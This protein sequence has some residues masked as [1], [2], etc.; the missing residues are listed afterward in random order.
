MTM[1][2]IL[3]QWVETG[4]G[5]LFVRTW[6][7]GNAEDR[8]PIL[9]VH[10]S[11]GCIALWRDFPERLAA[12]TLRPVIA[13]DR[14]GFGRSDPHP[15]TLGFDF[16]ADEAMRF[17][18][19]IRAQ[20]GLLQF[21]ACGHSVGGGMAVE[22]SAH[23]PEDCIAVVTMGAQAF[24]ERRTRDGIR[25]AKDDFAKPENLARL[26]KYHG[27]KARW[28]VDAW[29]AT[30]LAPGF[31]DWNLD[32]ALA[33]VRCPVLALHGEGDEYG[34]S[35]HPNRI[36]AGRGHAEIF[37]GAGHVL[38]REDGER[39]VRAIRHF[40]ATELRPDHSCE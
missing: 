11:L 35:E 1:P 30:W 17:I 33:R 32:S 29:T 20:L 22:T 25:Q 3:D 21:I 34:S 9:L 31:A 18:P 26:A 19:A 14:L 37:Q 10:D 13:Y 16:V 39:V 2:E 6:V 8:A 28:V 4:D 24:V 40:L 38:H 12:T 23:F 27:E 5:R 7:A 15:G 36:A